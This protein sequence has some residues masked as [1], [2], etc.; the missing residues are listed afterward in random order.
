MYRKDIQKQ[1]L[2]LASKVYIRFY[3]RCPN[4]SVY[5]A[6]NAS[7]AS[8]SSPLQ[9][10]LSTQSIRGFR[11]NVQVNRTRERWLSNSVPRHFCPHLSGIEQ[12]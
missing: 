12:K 7:D 3:D 11:N 5:N 10:M 8:H 1:S 6:I 2:F 4:D 9:S